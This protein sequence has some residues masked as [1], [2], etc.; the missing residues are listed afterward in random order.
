MT[1][2]TFTQTEQDLIEKLRAKY[3]HGDT[4]VVL[5]LSLPRVER[6][7][8]K[9]YLNHVSHQTSLVFFSLSSFLSP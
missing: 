7:E 5:H 1:F 9:T 2:S 4:S 6:D 3:K 8:M